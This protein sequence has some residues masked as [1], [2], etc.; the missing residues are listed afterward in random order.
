M[1]PVTK[2]SPC[3]ASG[4]TAAESA[5]SIETEDSAPVGAV[6]N[7]GPRPRRGGAGKGLNHR[8]RSLSPGPTRDSVG[9]GQRKTGWDQR[10]RASVHHHHHH[11]HR[12]FLMLSSVH[13]RGCGRPRRHHTPSI[14]GN[15]VGWGLK[16]GRPRVEQAPSPSRNEDPTPRCAGTRSSRS[17]PP[18]PFRPPPHTH[19]DQGAPTKPQALRQARRTLHAGSVQPRRSTG[20]ATR[21]LARSLSA[22][23]GVGGCVDGWMGGDGG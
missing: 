22:R 14:R 6:G 11:R 20:T 18:I 23:R 15:P 17:L 12:Y 4:G 7:T 2:V 5:S 16:T 19:S 3:A 8:G 9:R 21:A 10:R 1:G 13:S